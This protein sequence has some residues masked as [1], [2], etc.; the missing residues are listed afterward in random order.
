MRPEVN[1]LVPVRQPTVYLPHGGGPCFFMEPMPGLAPDAWDAMA[2]YLRGLPAMLPA[3]P[4]QILVISAHW[5]TAIPTV[6]AAQRHALLYDYYGFPEHTY[7]LQYPAQGSPALAQRVQ[8]LLGCAGIASQSDTQR[9]IDHGVFIPLLLA[10]PDADVPIVPLSL[11]AGLDARTH[12]AIGHALAPLRDDNVLIVGSG[13]SY[14]NLRSF[15]DPDPQAQVA[16]RQFQAW[17]E[18]RVAG[19]APESRD[20]ALAQWHGAP[21]AQACHPRSEHLLPL[22][23]AA[24]AGSGGHRTHRV[25]RQDP[26]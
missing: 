16:A 15:F 23:V 17:L 1:P 10:Y 24:G 7:R 3:P 21:G 4:R 22:M 26:R 25:P 12:L 9:G 5:E 6:G 14:H 8:D 18:Q 19:A 2:A 11:Q 20:A 13:M